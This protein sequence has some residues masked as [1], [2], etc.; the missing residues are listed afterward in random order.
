MKK[1]NTTTA[2]TGNIAPFGLR[3]LPELREK[4]ELAAKE[5]GRSM[6]AEIVQRLEASFEPPVVDESVVADRLLIM[7]RRAAQLE[8]EFEQKQLGL[9]LD[10]E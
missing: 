2:P 1:P 6:N 9:D 4:I 7:L 5:N 8:M 10:S 3:M